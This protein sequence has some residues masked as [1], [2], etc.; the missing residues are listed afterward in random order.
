MSSPSTSSPVTVNAVSVELTV[1]ACI[2]TFVTGLPKKY[3][4][5]VLYYVVQLPSNMATYHLCRTTCTSMLHV[6]ES[7]RTVCIKH[8]KL[9]C[10]FLIVQLDFFSSLLFVFKYTYI[11]KKIFRSTNV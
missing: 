7:Q 5:S 1:L 6:R 3:N 2:S 8:F 9:F 10:L 4:C 11:T